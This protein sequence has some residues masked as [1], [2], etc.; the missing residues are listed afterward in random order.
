MGIGSEKFLQ[1]R[2]LTFGAV[3]GALIMLATMYLRIPGATGYYHLGDGLIY[4]SAVLL[5]PVTGGMAAAVGSSLADVLGGYAAWALPTFVI[6]GL[7]AVAVGILARGSASMIRG[8]LAMI[9]GA[10]ITIAGYAG[11]T[12]LMYGAPAVLPETY[13]NLAQTGFGVLIG[14]LLVWWNRMRPGDMAA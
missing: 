2:R 11:A 7:T 14:L 3:F 8:A 12:Y 5:G 10:V 4:A 13:F 9:C 1:T 6:K